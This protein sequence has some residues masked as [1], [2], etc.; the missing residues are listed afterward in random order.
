VRVGGAIKRPIKIRDVKPAYPETAFAS[1][2]GGVVIVEAR[3]GADGSI[4][5]ARVLRSIPL[6]DEAALDAVRQWT[7]TPTVLD[8]EA[9]EVIATLTI[10]F[11][12]D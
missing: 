3:I 4:V 10:N 8:G 9:V 6:L 12:P 5:D 1:R 7:F 2:V 11:Q